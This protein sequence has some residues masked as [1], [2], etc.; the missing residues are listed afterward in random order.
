[1]PEESDAGIVCKAPAGIR[2]CVQEVRCFCLAAMRAVIIGRKL[3]HQIADPLEYSKVAD[4]E[5][6]GMISPGEFCDLRIRIPAK[7]MA[8]IR[9][10]QPEPPQDTIKPHD[11]N[12]ER[13]DGQRALALNA[14]FAVVSISP[15]TSAARVPATAIDTETTVRVSGLR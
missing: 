3:A 8:D 4:G 12:C 15:R 9:R 6:I 11:I 14:E 2:D 13:V 1:M 10:V 7:L 5:V